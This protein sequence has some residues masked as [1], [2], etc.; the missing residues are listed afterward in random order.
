MNDQQQEEEEEEKIEKFFSLIRNIRD[1]RDMLR[2]EV[3]RNDIHRDN[4]PKE[5]NI[6]DHKMKEIKIELADKSKVWTPSF[7]WEDFVP[8]QF[9]RSPKSGGETTKR[10]NL[11]V[12]EAKLDLNLS[13]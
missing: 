5:I 11:E 4:K 6:S 10:D 7:E 1:A 2:S 13:L 3:L 12:G 8:A 9:I